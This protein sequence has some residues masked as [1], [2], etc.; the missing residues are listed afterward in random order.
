MSYLIC[1]NETTGEVLHP[2]AVKLFPGF[3]RLD[4]DTVL[5]IVLAYDYCS[6]YS[7]YTEEERIRRSSL[8][9]WNDN[10]TDLVQRADIKLAIE[11]YKSLQYN[12]KIDLVRSYQKKI[13]DLTSSL[14]GI[15]SEKLIESNLNATN[16]LRDAIRNIEK[17]I[18]AAYQEEGTLVGNAKRSFL[19]VM[20]KNKERYFAVVKPK[21]TPK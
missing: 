6:P 8:H 4:K 16:L 17:E 20:H 14:E 1:I 13:D 10:R 2:D 11:A 21:E 5:F 12:P 3:A 15:S 18:L 19:E 7:Q 9:V